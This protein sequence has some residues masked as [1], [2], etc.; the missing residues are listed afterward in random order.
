MKK[1]LIYVSFDRSP[2]N[3]VTFLGPLAESQNF[4][5]LDCFTNGKGDRS[6][7]FNKFYEKDG[8]QWPF[9]VI[10]VNDPANQDQVGDAIYGLHGNLTGDIRFIFDSL[11]GMQD[12]WGGEEQVTKFYV[13][14][15]PR[16][17]ELDTIAYWIIEKNAHSSRL[18]AN[19]NKIAQVV[20][21]LSVKN[22]KSILKI[23]KAEKRTSPSINKAHGYTCE[24]GEIVFDLPRTQ[25]GRFDLGGG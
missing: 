13:R 4:T 22:G 15:C 2:K 14:N 7:V 8:A 24:Q 17:Y 1:P 23:S 25:S 6:E 3:V 19:I 20:I 12:L 10:K 18:K 5:I 9:Q 21:D 11:T 16:L